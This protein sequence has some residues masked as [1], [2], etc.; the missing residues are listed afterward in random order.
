MNVAVLLCILELLVRRDFPIKID[1]YIV[2]LSLCFLLSFLLR[3]ELIVIFIVM[4]FP[5]LF[6][7][8]K[9]I[10]KKYIKIIF[11]I[12]LILVGNGAL[13]YLE[14]S[15]YSSFKEY[16]KLRSE[17][18]DTYKGD[19]Y[20]DF[21]Q[22]ACIKAG[23]T[24]DD[25]YI[26]RKC[27]F[28]YDS[29]TFNS[30]NLDV[31]LEEN[32]YGYN[33]IILLRDTFLRIYNSFTNDS[34]IIVVT[35]LS[36]GCMILYHIDKVFKINKKQLFKIIGSVVLMTVMVLAF[37]GY[38]FPERISWP[39]FTY[40]FSFIYVLGDNMGGQLTN[41]EVIYKIDKKNKY[42]KIITI[43]VMACVLLFVG[44]SIIRFVNI[45]NSH[46][47][48]QKYLNAV[49]TAISID[50]VFS[51]TIIIPFD[52]ARTGIYNM[53]PFRNTCVFS[54]IKIIP[55]GWV[56]NTPHYENALGEIGIRDGNDLLD[57]IINNKN[58]LIMHKMNNDDNSLKDKGLL[59]SYLSHRMPGKSIKL[60]PKYNYTTKNRKGLIFYNVTSS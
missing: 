45:I 39:I 21:T 3:W 4:G 44:K 36:I 57:W 34:N 42:K 31:F 52:P 28:L 56:I 22:K 40:Y 20:G 26:F 10:N 25:Y 5:I 38:R 7:L 47:M 54:N 8:S 43:A 37:M 59:E 17:F 2:I 55:S 15:Q 23:W 6:F 49:L 12:T 27:W 58:I 48:Y 51:E 50:D 35:L 41:K 1:N 53:H 24:P 9:K 13:I 33:T 16:N 19:V 14:S 18:H 30:H 29:K 60:I 11:F 46:F 32:K